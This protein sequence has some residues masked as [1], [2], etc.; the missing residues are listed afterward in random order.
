M[1]A[2]PFPQAIFSVIEGLLP[3]GWDRVVFFAEYGEGFRCIEFYVKG[4]TGPF[5]KCYDLVGANQDEMYDAFDV[6]DSAIRSER[7][8]IPTDKLWRVMT[9]SVDCS[10]NFNID[11][12]YSGADEDPYEWKMEWKR[13][14]LA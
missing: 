12:D 13:R 1:T 7:S 5:I 3:S 11:Y 9:M 10:G 8:A 4:K 14:Y 2:E 6:A